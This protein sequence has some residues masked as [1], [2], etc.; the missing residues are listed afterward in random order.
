[1]DV[2]M[3][4]ATEE[5]IEGTRKLWAEKLDNVDGSFSKARVL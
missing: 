2:T 5:E 4:V 3:P 1:M